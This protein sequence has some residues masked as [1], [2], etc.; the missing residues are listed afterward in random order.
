MLQRMIA[1]SGHDGNI[2]PP[3]ATNGTKVTSKA[4]IDHWQAH[5]GRHASRDIY[6]GEA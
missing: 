6:A 4:G 5:E 1:S 3:K 2:R